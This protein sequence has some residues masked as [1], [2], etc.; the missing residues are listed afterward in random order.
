MAEKKEPVKAKKVN[1]DAW[2][3]RKLV[4]IHEMQD[5]AKAKAI[6]ER[7]MKIRRDK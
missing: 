6:A 7:V 4:A 1:V 2:I 5:D 3:K